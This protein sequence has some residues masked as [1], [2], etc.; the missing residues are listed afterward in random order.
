MDKKEHNKMIC[1]I[2]IYIYIYIMLQRDPIQFD[3]PIKFYDSV[4]S[5]NSIQFDEIQLSSPAVWHAV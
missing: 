5:D 2:W 3:D 4:Q 1:F